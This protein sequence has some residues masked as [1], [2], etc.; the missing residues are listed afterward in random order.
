MVLWTVAFRHDT[1]LSDVYF[2]I[3]LSVKEI[4]SQISMETKTGHFTLRKIS[5]YT[6]TKTFAIT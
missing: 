6:K 3:P 1:Y 4:L 2:T 5:E